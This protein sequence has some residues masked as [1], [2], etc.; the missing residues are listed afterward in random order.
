[1]NKDEMIRVIV[2]L[3]QLE[4]FARATNGNKF[5]PDDI[6]D[7]MNYVCEMLAKHIKR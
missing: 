3:S 7:E 2:L 6:L 4:G 1:M 5:L